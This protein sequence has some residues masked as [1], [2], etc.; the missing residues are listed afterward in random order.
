MHTKINKFKTVFCS[1][2]ELW[3]LITVNGIIGNF[4]VSADYRYDS[5]FIRALT[6][7]FLI[8]SSGSHIYLRNVCKVNGDIR[9][10]H[11]INFILCK[12]IGETLNTYHSGLFSWK[13]NYWYVIGRE[14]FAD[15]P[16]IEPRTF[17]ILAERFYQLR[18]RGF[19][20]VGE[21]GYNFEEH[22]SRITWLANNKSRVITV[23]RA[24]SKVPYWIRYFHGKSTN[25]I[26]SS[27]SEYLIDLM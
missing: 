21:T 22:F 25:N 1:D 5:V 13:P 23:I 20:Y 3:I 16:G 2:L 15:I 14:K 19:L 7:L 12:E 10:F 26:V 11:H 18:Y 6:I 9:V 27:I 4:R 24:N 17:P 8:Y